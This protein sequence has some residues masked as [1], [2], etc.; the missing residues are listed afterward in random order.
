MKLADQYDV[1]LDRERLSV[2]REDATLSIDATYTAELEVFPSAFY[3]W[4]FAVHVQATPAAASPVSRRV[5][6]R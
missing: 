1:P 2:E 3:P 6:A 4:E 5:P